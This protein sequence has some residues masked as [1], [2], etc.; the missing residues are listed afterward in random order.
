MVAWQINQHKFYFLQYSNNCAS[1]WFHQNLIFFWFSTRFDRLF[2]W[3]HCLKI[4]F[5]IPLPSTEANAIPRFSV[6]V[7]YYHP[8]V[9][10]NIIQ[11]CVCILISSNCHYGKHSLVLLLVI[12][13]RAQLHWQFSDL[14]PPSSLRCKQ[15]HCPTRSTW[16][17]N[18]PL[19][20]SV[21]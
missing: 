19:S 15:P 11:L 2:E 3:H 7:F 21:H 17:A 9:Y 13:R 10:F 8:I 5:Q 20:K 6:F 14:Q 16:V 4:S 12:H 18:Q 1:Y